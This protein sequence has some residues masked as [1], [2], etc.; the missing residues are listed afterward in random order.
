[1]D[2]STLDGTIDAARNLETG[3]TYTRS[4]PSRASAFFSEQKFENNSVRQKVII[5]NAVVAATIDNGA[6]FSVVSKFLLDELG[7]EIEQATNNT[8]ITAAGSQPRPLGNIN[9]FSICIGTFCIPVSFD[10]TDVNN[11]SV[12][13]GLKKEYCGPTT[14]DDEGGEKI[15]EGSVQVNLNVGPLTTHQKEKFDKLVEE[16]QDI[17]ARDES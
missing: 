11:P 13:T 5:E 12:T 16:C 2:I 10:T 14:E 17:F 8:L 4:I 3:Q 7:Y 6:A 15:E 9:Y 1:M